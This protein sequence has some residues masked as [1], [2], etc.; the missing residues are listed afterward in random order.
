MASM[1]TSNLFHPATRVMWA[2]TMA[3]VAR[4]HLST[5]VAER[6][7]QWSLNT[8]N[9]TAP[10][11]TVGIARLQLVDAKDVTTAEWNDHFIQ[12]S[13]YM[14]DARL[15]AQH[16]QSWSLLRCFSFSVFYFR[17]LWPLTFLESNSRMTEIS[18]YPSRTVNQVNVAE[19]FCVLVYLILK[20]LAC[21]FT[22]YR[23]Y[24]SPHIWF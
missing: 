1:N 7:W 23:E 2:T 15:T 17:F 21:Q 5:V 24:H 12:R 4:V 22:V 3:A 6:S 10:T 13:L 8:A 18:R 9:Q 19:V 11:D 14:H 16:F 20:L